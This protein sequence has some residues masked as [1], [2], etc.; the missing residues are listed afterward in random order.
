MMLC[1]LVSVALRLGSLCWCMSAFGHWLA[2]S[3]QFHDFRF[4]PS[5]AMH[6]D[7]MYKGML[8]ILYNYIKIGVT[9]SRRTLYGTGREFGSLEISQLHT[10]YVRLLTQLSWSGLGQNLVSAGS[11][12]RAAP[13]LKTRDD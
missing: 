5:V 9:L 11:V 3:M 10:S 13:L 12:R 8:Y 4:T 6:V 7:Y 1:V 2:S